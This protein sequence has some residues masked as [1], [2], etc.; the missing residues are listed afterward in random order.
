MTINNW[1]KNRTSPQLR[2]VPRIIEFLGYV[3]YYCTPRTL[4]ERIVV[5]PRLLGVTQKE[6]AHRLGV[7]PSTLGRW[8]RDK[9][10]PSG[11]CHDRLL[12]FLADQPLDSR[13]ISKSR[14]S[15]THR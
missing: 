4:G 15:V 7:D 13:K 1:E 9:G 14:R 5:A 3:P 12:T 8:K 11:R 10:K 2:F 6:L